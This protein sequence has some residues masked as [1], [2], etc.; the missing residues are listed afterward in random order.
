MTRRSIIPSRDL[1]STD[2]NVNLNSGGLLGDLLASLGIT[3]SSSGVDVDIATL[4]NRL[5]SS[6]AVPIPT[7]GETL[8]ANL[9]AT[10]DICVGT[11]V[12]QTLLD[13][14]TKVVNSLLSSLL[15]VTANLEVNSSSPVD[16]NTA[17]LDLQLCGSSGDSLEA[18]L[19]SILKEVADLF[20]GAL[21]EVKIVTSCS[22]GGPVCTPAT[23]TL[24]N[25]PPSPSSISVPVPSSSI[26]PS[27]SS[28][29][30]GTN[31]SGLVD[32]L[33]MEVQGILANLGLGSANPTLDAVADPTIV[34]SVA[35]SDTLSSVD[36]LVDTILALT[37][38]VLD[39][40]MPIEINLTVQANPDST[41][42]PVPSGLSEGD[43]V[44]I[45]LDLSAILN[46]ILSEALDI[47]D[48]V[49][50]GVVGVLADLLKVDVVANVNGGT[51]CG[52]SQTRR[53]SGKT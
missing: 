40:L 4:V 17:S 12:S 42:P 50:S 37:R 16:P 52:C 34:V 14:I 29:F 35:L 49:S 11:G 43:S 26:S 8:S 21:T 23:S 39:T 51:G 32:S 44:V 13:T 3:P 9:E 27:P 20:N 33:L 18:I 47:V 15:G 28:T 1:L 10:L 22:A 36:G 6:L 24:S 45:D 19:T 46:D 5:L 7:S 25:L 30:N 31:P 41:S 2:Q 38:Q 48:Q 53:A